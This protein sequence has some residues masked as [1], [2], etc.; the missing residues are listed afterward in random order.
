MRGKFAAA[1]LHTPYGGL[2]D[3]VH[4]DAIPSLA[5]AVARWAA[6]YGCYQLPGGR[7]RGVQYSNIGLQRGA[8]RAC[9]VERILPLLH[10]SIY[11][12]Q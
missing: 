4:E 9:G 2:I 3:E 12:I 11:I 1:H 10:L 7:L 6:H 5:A 8:G